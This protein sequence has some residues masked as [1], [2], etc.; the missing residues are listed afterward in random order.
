MNP[1]QVSAFMCELKDT[2]DDFCCKD[3]E[4]DSDED[5][6]EEEL[7]TE[8]SKKKN[9]DYELKKITS[10]M[11][12]CHYNFSPQFAIQMNDIIISHLCCV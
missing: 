4:E 11:A 1:I 8:R 9:M 12:N 6:D 10:K 2:I 7:E 3:D 5:D